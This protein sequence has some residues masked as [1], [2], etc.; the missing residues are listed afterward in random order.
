MPSP[1]RPGGHTHSKRCDALTAASLSRQIA[2]RWHVE[3]PIAH[4]FTLTLLQSLLM[5]YPAAIM[6]G[7]I[8]L[9][10]H[11]AVFFP[12]MLHSQTLTCIVGRL[13]CAAADL[14]VRHGV[15]E[16]W[17]ACRGALSCHVDTHKIGRVLQ[18]AVGPVAPIPA[19][20][21]SVVTLLASIQDPVGAGGVVCYCAH[22]KHAG[23]VGMREGFCLAAH[24]RAHCFNRHGL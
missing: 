4:S 14:L 21:V 12:C 6:V 8:H 1:M 13:V 19:E 11:R 22:E 9:A 20:L 18:L 17:T 24:W 10:T 2:L 7:D 3:V 16:R 23:Q 5:T 15:R